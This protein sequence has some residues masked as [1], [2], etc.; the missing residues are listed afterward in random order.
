[1]VGG[2]GAGRSGE[3]TGRSGA[4]AID[5]DGHVL[6][7][8]DAWASLPDVFRPRIERDRIGYEHVIVGDREVVAVSLGLLATPGSKMS[9]RSSFRTIE[10]ALPGGYDPVRR[11]A[12]MDTEGIDAAVLYPSVG[13]NF[14]AVEDADAAVALAR[15]YND[16]LAGYCS[17]DPA[18]LF[19]AAMV[20]LQDPEAAAAELRRATRDLGFPAAFVRPNPVCGRSIADPAHEVVWETVEELGVALGIHEGSSVIIPTLGSDR[21]FNPFVLHAVSHPFEQMLACAQLIASGVLERHPGLRVVFLESG[22]TWA[23]F[24]LERLDEQ[25]HGFGDFC[26]EMRLR[27][28]EYFARQCW[29]SAEVDESALAAI[30]PIVGEERIVWGSDYPHHDATFPGALRE[31]ER[32]ISPLPERARERILGRN[33]MELYGLERAHTPAPSGEAD[34]PARAASSVGTGERALG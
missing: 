27:P 14:W 25:V 12:D 16:W 1:M 9:D 13:L 17:Q 28:S 3:E 32:A 22:A 26:P 30:A 4:A 23:A 34:A 15:A 6:E 31:L 29:I 2:S 7:P 20:P 8:M 21:P 19:G 11:L 10:E 24:W 5:A 33:A 18:R